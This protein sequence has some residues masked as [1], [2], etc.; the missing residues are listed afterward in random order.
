MAEKK[1]ELDTARLDALVRR[2]TELVTKMQEFCLDLAKLD[3]DIVKAGG[4]TRAAIAGT[5]GATIAG[6]IGA[7][8]ASTAGLFKKE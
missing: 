3:L 4:L 8:V 1:A 7:T 2:R 5:I 6:T